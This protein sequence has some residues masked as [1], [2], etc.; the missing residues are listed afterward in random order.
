MPP[1]LP[2][3]SK[4]A[5]N[6][7]RGIALG[8]SCAIGV[9]VEDRRRRISTLRTVLSNKEKLKSAK[10]Y[11]G[12][13]D[14]AA[15]QL[16][17]SIFLE[18]E[19]RL[20]QLDDRTKTRNASLNTESTTTS[21]LDDILDPSSS[22]TTAQTE[23]SIPPPMQKKN[24]T[25]SLES[26][27][28]TAT[29]SQTRINVPAINAHGARQTGKT[30]VSRTRSEV[31]DESIRT[32]TSILAGVENGGLDRALENFF[33]T[34]RSYYS[35][36]KFDEKWIAVSAQLSRAC[37]AEGRWDDASK[38]LTTTINAG[39]LD[40]SQFHA[41][42]PLS[43]VKFHLRQ[44]NED[45]RCL[46][47]AIASATH[48]F[49]ATFKDR[50]QMKVAELESVARHLFTQNLLS[51]RFAVLHNI[52]WRV[53]CYGENVAFTGW[54][55]QKLYQYGDYKNAVK[56]FLLNYSKMNPGVECYNKTVDCVVYSVE[57][58]RGLK[59]RQVLQ[60]LEKMNRPGNGFLRS[61]WIMRLLQAHWRRDKDFPAV[62]KFF[63]QVISSG[64]L[65]KVNHPEGPYR[66]MVEIS[67][68]AGENHSIISYCK[69]VIQKYPDM[70]SDVALRGFLALALA[71]VGDWDG[72]LD[73]FTEMRALKC[74]QETQYDDAFVMVLKVFADTHPVAEVRDFVLKY[75][76]DLGVR[77]HLYTAT[78][79]A[80]KY[81]ECHDIPGFSSWLTYCSETGVVLDSGFC[82]PI[83]H[84]CR[85]KFGLSYNELREIYL[86]MKRLN[87]TF[88]DDVTQRIMSQAAM[89][90][91]R[92]TGSKKIY[93]LHK[94]AYTGRTANSRDVYEAMNQELHKG[95]PAS[96]ISIYKRAL[97][98]G[99]PSCRHCLQLAVLAALRSHQDGTNSA[100]SI[101][102][103][104]HAQGD[105]VNLAVSTFIK[106][107]LDHLRTDVEDV[108]L[109]M[110]NMTRLFESLDIIID[111]SVL[112]HMAM[113]CV[114]MGHFNKVLPLCSL[115][116]DRAGAKNFC[117][118]RQS[119]RALLMAYEKLR[120][121]EGMRKLTS[122]LLA[123]RYAADQH[124]LLYLRASRRSIQRL[125]R[126]G[127]VDE[128][129]DI[130]DSTLDTVTRRRAETRMTG[131]AMAE[132]TLRIMQDAVANLEG[133]NKD[134]L[135][136]E[137]D[138][139]CSD[140]SRLVS[141]A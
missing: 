91:K 12:M 38:V 15:L 26:V 62:K 121:V 140:T 110:R 47:E 71:K 48:I 87:P 104:A 9:I 50:P 126:G 113:I 69:A 34:S 73:A 112:T 92:V 130:L 67:V 106:F 30:T 123:S 54:V 6:A 128:L 18:D 41:H 60:S 22:P 3:P 125:C 43:V 84:N 99:M 80:N 2:V 29:F 7:L 134:Y 33:E 81:G 5:I 85:T 103:K 135:Q 77:M 141:V 68:K 115:A 102:R 76:N 20:H 49:L 132:E 23:I 35:F 59:A 13:A 117:F 136:Y 24:P 55:I 100:L 95:R 46:P 105:D 89:T 39:A 53:I 74:L 32:I 122:D 19:L 52:Y 36:K 42:E 8:T 79:V 27:R 37:Q 101:I 28:P 57:G 97:N 58:L 31:L 116:M 75:T 78:L 86:E 127:Y 17:E 66:T 40:E 56:Y 61:R 96:A 25:P 109:H 108:L 107:Q 16:D 63:Q 133:I 72:V 83:L 90:G 120:D 119:I 21:E 10:Q 98:F 131:K 14:G 1:P 129:L 118:S 139:A 45:G 93:A 44:V 64:L 65:K 111:P 88:A 138:E 11:H 70:A 4:V 114:K 51:Y 94:L 124:V 82:N 137:D